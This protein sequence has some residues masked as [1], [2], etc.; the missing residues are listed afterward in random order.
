[1]INSMTLLPAA[2]ISRIC[3]R[4]SRRIEALKAPARPRSEVAT[5][6]RWVS[7]LPVPTSSGG[8]P[9]RA[10][11]R[12]A[13]EASTRSIRSAKG[14]AASTC[15]T[16]RRSLEAAT[17][18]IAEVI[19]WVDLTLRIRI[20][21][22]LRL[23]TGQAPLASSEGPDEAVEELLEPLLHCRGDFLV[24]ADR[25]KQFRLRVAQLA[26]QRRFEAANVRHG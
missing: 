4:A 9:G 10:A 6:M 13:R 1:M 5:T 21:K 23:G 20:R 8:A 15:S 16:A 18:F 3:R 12:P 26:Q 24:R 7:S 14:R 17:T 2:S 19:F 25:V 11:I 22:D